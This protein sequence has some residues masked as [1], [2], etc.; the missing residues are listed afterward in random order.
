VVRLFEKI[1]EENRVTTVKPGIGS[2]FI[3][4]LFG[5][6]PFVAGF[7]AV[8]LGQWQ[9]A[10]TFI[11]LGTAFAFGPACR[12]RISWDENWLR[13][14]GLVSSK[15]V[16]F[17]DIERFDIGGPY[18][19]YGLGPTVGLCILGH[20]SSEPVMII[21]IKPFSRKDIKRLVDRLNRVIGED[22]Y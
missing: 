12:Y 10:I 9:A 7:D 20:L 15:K 18:Y 16:L 2:C 3:F 19:K 17:S 1:T 4:G 11:S 21:N 13:Y 22:V 8:R 14:R 5:L 6:L